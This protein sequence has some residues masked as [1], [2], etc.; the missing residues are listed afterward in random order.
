MMQTTERCGR[1]SSLLLYYGFRH[2]VEA[3]ITQNSA[4]GLLESAGGAPV[5]CYCLS[6]GERSDA[7]AMQVAAVIQEVYGENVVGPLRIL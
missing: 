6:L 7:P 4:V 3:D 1:S 2:T 5:V